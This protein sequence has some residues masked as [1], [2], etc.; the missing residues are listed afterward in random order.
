MNVGSLD[1]ARWKKGLKKSSSPHRSSGAENISSLLIVTCERSFE[2]PRRKYANET[3]RKSVLLNLPCPSGETLG[4]IKT[5]GEGGTLGSSLGL[6]IITSVRVLVDSKWP[7]SFGAVSHL[8]LTFTTA[9]PS[10]FFKLDRSGTQK[11]A[12]LS[13]RELHT[14]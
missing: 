11:N 1:W 13:P 2:I 7:Y 5:V 3:A 14:S 9:L 8:S 12:F 6:V 4:M 10:T